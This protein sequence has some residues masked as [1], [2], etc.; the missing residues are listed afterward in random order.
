MYIVDGLNVT[1]GSLYG[2]GVTFYNT[3]GNPLS[4]IEIEGGAHVEFSAT[5]DVYSD[6]NN[7][8]FFN[9]RDAGPQPKYDAKIIGTST[10]IFEGVQYFPTVEL[11]FGGNQD[12]TIDLFSQLI[13]L[14][15]NLHGTANVSGNYGYSNPDRV[16]TTNRVSFVE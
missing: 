5:N 10:S 6:Y 15:I 2:D 4:N 12:T 16:P 7:I 9:S 14:T 3:G 1:G 8:L 11:E 13:A